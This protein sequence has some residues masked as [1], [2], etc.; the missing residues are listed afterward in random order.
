MARALQRR[1]K[2]GPLTFGPGGGRSPCST[3]MFSSLFA[4][5]APEPD[6]NKVCNAVVNAPFCTKSALATA[7]CPYAHWL[8]RRRAME[9]H[10][11]KSRLG[12]QAGKGRTRFRALGFGPALRTLASRWVPCLFQHYAPPVPHGDSEAVW[13]WEDSEAAQTHGASVFSQHTATSSARCHRSQVALSCL[14]ATQGC[15]HPRTGHLGPGERR[16]QHCQGA[17]TGAPNPFSETPKPPA[18][19]ARPPRIYHSYKLQVPGPCRPAGPAGK[20]AW[21]AQT[22]LQTPYHALV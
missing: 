4:P 9:R 19:R 18:H 8:C 12:S 3:R 11:Q 10:L 15:S 20:Q 6:A 13:A 14:L 17:N 2:Q 1:D 5:L 16:Q 7:L 21:T 22:Q